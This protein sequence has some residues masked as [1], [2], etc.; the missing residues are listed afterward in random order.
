MDSDFFGTSAHGGDSISWCGFHPDAQCPLF[1]G[2]YGQ[3]NQRI[4]FLERSVP[5][6]YGVGGDFED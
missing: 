2:V 4:V 3:L 1:S 6:Y 5:A